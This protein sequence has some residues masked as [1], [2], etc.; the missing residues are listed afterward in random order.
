[1]AS[2]D[3]QMNGSGN[4]FRATS[5]S[6]TAANLRMAEQNSKAYSSPMQAASRKNYNQ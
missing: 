2:S 4:Q 6:L 5:D 1:M 3:D